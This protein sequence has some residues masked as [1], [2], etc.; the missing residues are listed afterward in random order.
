MRFVVQSKKATLINVLVILFSLSF[1]IFVFS[2]IFYRLES[3][4]LLPSQI[5]LDLKG[6]LEEFLEPKPI[7][8]VLEQMH[9][10]LFIFNTALLILSSILYR[11]FT[12]KKVKFILIVSGFFSMYFEELSTLAVIYLDDKFSYVV[13]IGFFVM[14]F[15]M[16]LINSINLI[17]FLTGKIK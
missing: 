16:T 7:S 9:I 11:T 2:L 13:S 14:V 17:S 5:V 12:D 15:I 1:Y 8:T 6:N 10:N 4:T 3:N